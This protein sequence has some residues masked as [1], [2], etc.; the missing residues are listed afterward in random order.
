MSNNERMVRCVDICQPIDIVNKECKQL[1]DNGYLLVDQDGW[2]CY[3]CLIYELPMGIY[4]DE[5]I[6]KHKEFVEYCKAHRKLIDEIL[7]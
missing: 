4:K 5:V 1:E 7:N 6:K 2:D 3:E